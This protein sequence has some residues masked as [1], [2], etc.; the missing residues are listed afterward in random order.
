M[1]VRRKSDGDDTSWGG[2]LDEGGVEEDPEEDEG[3]S[4]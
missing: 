4:D 2:G 1:N 3:A